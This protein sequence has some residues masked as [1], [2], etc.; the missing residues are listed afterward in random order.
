MGSF[1]Q[2]C[3][4]TCIYIIFFSPSH[5]EIGNIISNEKDSSESKDD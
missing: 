4:Y 2:D 1:P 5:T 3:W